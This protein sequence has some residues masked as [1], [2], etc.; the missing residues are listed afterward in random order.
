MYAG[1]VIHFRDFLEAFRTEDFDIDYLTA[2]R[3]HFM[4]NG[5]S[6]R[7]VEGGDLGFYVRK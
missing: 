6:K 2:N 3:F 4:G 1:S 5:L 7:E